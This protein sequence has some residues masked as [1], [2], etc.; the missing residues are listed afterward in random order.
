MPVAAEFID[1]KLKGR[2]HVQ[3]S[4][5]HEKLR[6]AFAPPAA[7]VIAQAADID[8][9]GPALLHCRRHLSVPD[10]E[11]D[12]HDINVALPKRDRQ[13]KAQC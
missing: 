5:H 4:V 6:S 1:Q 12:A 13:A 9:L 10:S 2:G 3:Q 8:E 11:F 7:H